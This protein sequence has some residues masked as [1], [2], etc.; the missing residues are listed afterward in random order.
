MKRLLTFFAFALVLASCGVTSPRQA[1]SQASQQEAQTSSLDNLFSRQDEYLAAIDHMSIPAACME[2]DAMIS[3]ARDSVI[4]DSVAVRSYRHFRNSK[5]MGSENVAVH[6]FDTWF[7]TY[8]ILFPTI[9]E[10]EDASLYAFVNRQSLIGS[11]PSELTMT[12]L[13]GQEVTFPSHNGHRTIVYFY[14][15]DCPKCLL[16][17]LELKKF[18][19][20]KCPDVELF[21]IY[22]GDDIAVW[23][24]YVAKN[25][26]IP[27]SKGTICH[28]HGEDTDFVSVYGVIQTPRLFLLDENGVIIG[29]N[30]D[31]DA[32]SKLLH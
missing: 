25:L 14:S 29:R 11:K 30:L 13:N 28:L 7:A 15:A 17:S 6:I 26:N 24:T 23:N 16:T 8:K 10:F 21:T 4:R 19:V 2:V 18:I 32:L 27:S 20:S 9:D 1:S 31:V 22:T 5:V 12:D 3:V